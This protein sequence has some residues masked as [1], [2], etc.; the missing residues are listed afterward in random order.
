MGWDE[1]PGV[2]IERETRA[3]PI[4]IGDFS[5]LLVLVSMPEKYNPYSVVFVD[6]IVQLVFVGVVFW[7]TTITIT[8]LAPK[9]QYIE[10]FCSFF[11]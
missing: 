7:E 3:Y 6:S 1:Q 5:S 11:F 8:L 4:I 9:S 2:G 10:L